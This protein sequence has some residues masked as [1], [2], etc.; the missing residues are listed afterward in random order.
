[1]SDSKYW[2]EQNNSGHNVFAAQGE[3][4]IYL[5]KMEDYFNDGLEALKQRLYPKAVERFENFL[6]TAAS[7]SDAARGNGVSG[8]PGASV[9]PGEIQAKAARAH[10]YAVL[11]QLGRSRPSY[12]S[13]DV[14]R[15]IDTHLESA[16]RAG[17]GRPVSALADVVWAIVKD[18][19]YTAQ[20]LRAGDPSASELRQS[21]AYL[22]REDIGTLV[23]HL[24][25][26]EGETWKALAG[27]AADRGFAAPEVFGE[28]KRRAISPDRHE[29][30]RKYFTKT[31]DPVNPAPHILAFSGVALLVIAAVASRSF[32]SVL[33]IAGAAWL[34]KK[35]FD[36]YKV[37]R[38]Y[39][40]ALA[41]AE[42]KPPEEELDNWLA[43]D[44]EY[45]TRKGARKLRLTPREERN[46]GDLLVQEQVVVGV[47][48]PGETRNGRVPGVRFGKDGRLRADHY[49]VL[50]LFLTDRMISTYR[51]VLE[52][53]TGELLLDEMREYHYANIVGVSA[54]SIPVS[55][56]IQE[57][58]EV[59]S[60]KEVDI[61]LI[62]QFSLSI[63]NG[64]S[65]PVT[66]GFGGGRFEDS[67]GKVVW[68]GN[69]HALSI[70]QSMVRSR[71]GR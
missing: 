34:G 4:N 38:E 61:S 24:A 68:R 13:V 47:A 23:E 55:R 67:D 43:E 10:V 71:H 51:S 11:G 70:I 62:H 33:L 9:A 48:K 26:A 7:V 36:R 22:D 49:D 63:V 60:D 66:T 5:Q 37:Y 30:V 45:I 46:G 69:E 53:A 16:R 15:R 52:F 42:P 18:D 35:G 19:F 57:L 17:A 25:P 21:L 54:V 12:H 56:P 6:S 40:K 8:P 20:G 28:E 3:Q 65:M 50:I 31:P 59:V 41:A 1:M 44:I 64:E 39:R 29:K 32:L 2:Y 14:I 58:V 27:L